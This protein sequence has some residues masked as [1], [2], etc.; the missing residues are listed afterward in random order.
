MSFLQSCQ[1]RLEN[2]EIS[3]NSSAEFLGNSQNNKHAQTIQNATNART[4]S[5]QSKKLNKIF[6]VHFI[7]LLFFSNMSY[8]KKLLLGSK[9]EDYYR[10][11]SLFR[12]SKL[13]YKFDVSGAEFSEQDSFGSRVHYRL[14]V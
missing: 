2:N 3:C 1:N 6:K 9:N 13:P 4:R 14:Q 5:F 8:M 12:S 11:D 10:N 7:F